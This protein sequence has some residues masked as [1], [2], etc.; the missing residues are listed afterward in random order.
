[1]NTIKKVFIA[2]GVIW[3]LVLTGVVASPSLRS[4]AV[5]L[6]A[7]V[8]QEAFWFVNGL[9]LGSS[10]F[11]VNWSPAVSMT[12]GKNQ[13]AW[14]NTTGKTIYTS[15]V[16]ANCIMTLGASSTV[17]TASTSM[18]LWI[19]TSTTAT[20]GDPAIGT[21]PL[22]GS[23]LDKVLIATS[24]A[25]GAIH[26]GITNS[27][28]SGSNEQGDVAVTNGQYILAAMESVNASPIGETATSTARGFN[29]LCSYPYFTQ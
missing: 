12:T 23:I 7:Q 2:A 3:L 1:M 22:L 27:T 15:S 26:D 19:G 9:Q 10:G 6:G 5:K 28:L 14:Q 24:S 17:T 18:Y 16:E 8:Q 13:V 20:V 11:T 21:Q 29:L 25:V 4:S